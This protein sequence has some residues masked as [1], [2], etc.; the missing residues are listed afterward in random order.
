M[1]FASGSS[2]YR[3]HSGG[4]KA[5]AIGGLL[6]SKGFWDPCQL[7]QGEGGVTPW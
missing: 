5:Q 6:F 1:T 7:A 2:G 3:E 4:Y